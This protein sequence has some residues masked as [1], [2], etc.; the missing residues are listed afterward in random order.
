MKKS[1]VHFP[2]MHVHWLSTLQ[3]R[4]VNPGCCL[5]D[6]SLIVDSENSSSSDSF[7]NFLG[8]KVFS[9]AEYLKFRNF[10]PESSELNLRLSDIKFS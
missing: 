10:L 8:S 7:I 5:V 3:E 6:V 1:R 9:I 4:A 2:S